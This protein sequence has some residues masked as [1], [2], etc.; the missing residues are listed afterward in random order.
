MERWAS[1]RQVWQE[2]GHRDAASRNLYAFGILLYM[3]VLL[4]GGGRDA[5]AQT[6]F[7]PEFQ[8]DRD[9]V[10]I[11]FEYRN[12]EILIHGEADNKQDLTLL[13][14]SGASSPVFDKDLG[15]N[16]YHLGDNVVK[17]AEGVSRAESVWLNILS[18]GGKENSVH[19]NNLSVLLSDLSQISKVLGRKVDGIVGGSFLTGFV[20]EIDYQRQVLRFYNPHL[21][22]IADKKPDNQRTFMFD[23][24]STDE[25]QG[26]HLVHV[27]GKLH[28]KYDYDFLLD[29][30]SGGYVNVSATAAEAAGLLTSQTPRIATTSY[31]VSHT[32]RGAKIRAT[33]LTIGAINLSNRIIQVDYRNE[34]ATGQSGILGNR[35]LQNY[36]IT[37]DYPRHKLWMERATETEELDDA[38]KPALGFSVRTNGQTATIER[39]VKNS[40]ADLSGVHSG[41]VLVSINGQ[42]V[43]EMTTVQMAN[44]LVTPHGATTLALTRGA[45]PADGTG[46]DFYALTLMPTSPLDWG[47]PSPSH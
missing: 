5:R 30:G 19:V 43:R 35:F 4:V 34:D 23:L 26:K 47:A 20:L 6:H 41:D 28:V 40:P 46:G 31:S 25:H 14:D 38:E 45:N 9:I 1:G 8:M 24:D 36:R 10:E 37:L 42:A 33:F 3:L 39:V 11:P 7:I 17:E 29:T 44:L 22:S 12:H 32:F 27:A 13:L 16:T 18:I 15:L 2:T 21:Y